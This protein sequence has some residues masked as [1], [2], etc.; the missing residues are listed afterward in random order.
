M[1]PHGFLELQ[2]SPFLICSE[3]HKAVGGRKS[4]DCYSY[5][6]EDE[7]KRLERPPALGL[8]ATHPPSS[9]WP[10]TFLWGTPQR[11]PPK[12]YIAV[13]VLAVC[14]GLAHWSTPF[15]FQAT[16]MAWELSQAND[17]AIPSS[18]WGRITAKEALSTGKFYLKMRAG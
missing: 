13:F 9:D 4:A 5:L 6:I 12:D 3:S 10:L 2:S 1:Y 14:V 16:R 7:T 18:T 8:L 17:N 15:I 11:L